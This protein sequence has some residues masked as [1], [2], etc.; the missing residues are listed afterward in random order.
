M[1]RRSLLAA[2][3]LALPASARAQRSAWLTRLGQDTVS[4]ERAERKGNRIA[5]R[6]VQTIPL[7]K[8]I[9]FVF[10]LNTAGGVSHYGMQVHDTAGTAPDRPRVT[11]D[12][13]FAKSDIVAILTRGGKTDTTHVPAGPIPVPYMYNNWTLMEQLTREMAR[14]GTDSLSF[15]WYNA[16]EKELQPAGRVAWRAG[17]R[18][19]ASAVTSVTPSA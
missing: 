11:L 7:V 4:V 13:S 17:A 5:G 15:A 14:A 6:Y 12:V 8:T 10:D 3:L 16:G 19:N 9:D 18:P 1:Q 2:A